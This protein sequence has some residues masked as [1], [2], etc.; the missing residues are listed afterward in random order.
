MYVGSFCLLT[1]V[2]CAA[3]VCR[4]GLLGSNINCNSLGP[5]IFRE[6]FFKLL[7]EGFTRGFSEKR[8]L[9]RAIRGALEAAIIQTRVSSPIC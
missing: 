6:M 5:D 4:E 3:G 1:L 8:M 9:E 2:Y 7:S